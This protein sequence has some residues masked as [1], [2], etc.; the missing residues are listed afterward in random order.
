MIH[1]MWER[2]NENRTE[3]AGGKR[4]KRKKPAPSMTPSNHVDGACDDLGSCERPVFLCAVIDV[5]QE[6]A[7]LLRSG[8]GC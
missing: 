3:V 7:Q 4:E 6:V 2:M 1:W 5:K 8:E